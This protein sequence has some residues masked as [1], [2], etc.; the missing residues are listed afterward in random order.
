MSRLV[1]LLAVLLTAGCGGPSGPS[2]VVRANSEPVDDVSIQSAQPAAGSTLP[3]GS[4]VTLRYVLS[5]ELV[6]ADSGFIGM[7]VQDQD[8]RRLPTPVVQPSAV[9]TRGK[10][11]TELT[12]TFEVPREDFV[13]GLRVFMPLFAGSE[14]STGK[15]AAVQYLVR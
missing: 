6:T 8:D 3:R 10:G 9:V 5:Y 11:S 15:F 1:V 2:S 4:T 7:S 12:V 14:R 13:T